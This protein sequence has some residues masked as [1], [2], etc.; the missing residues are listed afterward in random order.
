MYTPQVRKSRSGVPVLRKDEFDIIGEEYVRD[1]QPEVLTNPAPID[2]ERFVECYLGMAVD[3]Q[4]LS[5]NGIYLG[6]TVFNDT[7][8]VIVYST[9]T[10]RAEFISAKARTVIIDRSLI[11][12]E[13]SWHRYRFTLGHE[14]AH[15]IFHSDFFSYNPNQCTLNGYATPPMIQCRVDSGKIGKRDPKTWT[16]RERME[17]QANQLSSAILMPAAA[18]R[19]IAKKY[20]TLASV[21]HDPALLRDVAK[22]FDVSPEAATYRLRGLGL[23]S[24][25]FTATRAA[26]DFI[27]IFPSDAE[28]EPMCGV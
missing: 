22:T 5:N 15:D 7:D 6:M 23:V 10:R 27:D 19:Q 25:S 20:E 4:Y 21:L 14:G 18:V 8:C 11:E 3:Y 28:L 1:F 12:N 9:E 24:P 26:L 16:D 17:Y 13:K 2:I